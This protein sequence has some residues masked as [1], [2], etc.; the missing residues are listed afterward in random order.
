MNS[1]KLSQVPDFGGIFCPIL[2]QEKDEFLSRTV[3]AQ[4]DENSSNKL[5]IDIIVVG[6]PYIY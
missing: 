5:N 3:S 4:F 1:I 6:I 2:G